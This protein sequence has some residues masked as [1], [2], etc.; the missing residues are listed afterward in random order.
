MPRGC[1]CHW[2]SDRG[3]P[4][5]SGSPWTATSSSTLRP[6]PRSGHPLCEEP[7]VRRQFA[8]AQGGTEHFSHRDGPPLLSS[9]VGFRLRD[10]DTVTLGGLRYACRWFGLLSNGRSR[11]RYEI[12]GSKQSQAV[13][14]HEGQ[15]VILGIR[16]HRLYIGR[17]APHTGH[18]QPPAKVL[19]HAAGP[20]LHH[21]PSD[22]TQLRLGNEYERR[23]TY[24]TVS[25]Q[26]AKTTPE[27]SI[28]PST[29]LLS[30]I[31]M[32]LR[33][34]SATSTQSPLL[35]LSELLRQKALA[36]PSALS[37]T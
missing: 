27:W 34:R 13:C 4:S 18:N 35:I 19:R 14:R 8:A 9:S 10:A 36:R 31:L 32:R 24:S 30:R 15:V 33:A 29:P 12:I 17:S 26:P 23:V 3:V 25:T 20:V 2:W 7:A 6:A 5:L 37:V 22:I 16:C 11:M 1:A 21:R 28:G